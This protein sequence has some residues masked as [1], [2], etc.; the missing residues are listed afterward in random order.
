MQ[1]RFVLWNVKHFA[2]CYNKGVERRFRHFLKFKMADKDDL[3]IKC[4][5]IE[6][7]RK[8]ANLSCNL[9]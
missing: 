1:Y 2:C 4:L 7:G 3:M 5:G 9:S 6:N 8:W